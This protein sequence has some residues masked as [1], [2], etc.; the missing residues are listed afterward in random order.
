M[1]KPI[2]AATAT[3]ARATNLILVS[4][5]FVTISLLLLISSHH[6]NKFEV[7]VR[8]SFH[9]RQGVV[10]QLIDPCRREGGDDPNAAVSRRPVS[11]HGLP[12]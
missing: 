3:A 7:L 5:G 8:I 10:N 4:G 6:H 11:P 1:P 12:L 9:G 2:P